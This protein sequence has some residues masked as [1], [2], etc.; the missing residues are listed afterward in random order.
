MLFSSILRDSATT[1]FPLPNHIE[2]G[3]HATGSVLQYP[4]DDHPYR[5]LIHDRDSIFSEDVDKSL[6]NLGVR[7]LPTLVRAP[8]ANSVCE[9]LGGSLRRECLDF[10]IPF[11]ERHLQMTIRDLTT[12]YKRGRPHSALG[13]GLPEPM[14]DPVPPNEHRHMLPLGYRVVKRSVLGGLHHEYGLVKEAA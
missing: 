8:K 1:T 4:N 6:T 14:S 5:F 10:L 11:N 2:F 3:R 7:I 9:R 12:H 13:S